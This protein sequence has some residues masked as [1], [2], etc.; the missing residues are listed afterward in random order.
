MGVIESTSNIDSLSE[1][2]IGV[3]VRTVVKNLL[4]Q[5]VVS[6][7]EVQLMQMKQYSKETFDIQYPLL[8]PVQSTN[9]RHPAR[10]Y[11]SPITVYG[12]KYFL[13]SEWYEVPANND[14]PYLLKWIALHTDD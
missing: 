1:M 9:G 4:E 12:K 6:E 10:Y 7:E 2:K 5:G 13:C 11:S 14:R 8:M 3:I